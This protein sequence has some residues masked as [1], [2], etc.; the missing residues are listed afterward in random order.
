MENDRKE[1]LS[2]ISHSD[3][4]DQSDDDRKKKEIVKGKRDFT[5]QELD[6]KIYITFSETL[7]NFMY[8]APS[9]KYFTN[10]IGKILIQ[11][12]IFTKIIFISIECLQILFI[13]IIYLNH[14]YINRSKN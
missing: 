13:K 6:Q 10:K 9:Q 7:T 1:D 12:K 5:E 2:V 8:F 3:A 14:F 11:I 4:M